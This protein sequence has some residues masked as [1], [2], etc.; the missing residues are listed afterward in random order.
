[1]K[2]TLNSQDFEVNEEKIELA[3]KYYYQLSNEVAY[4]LD[5]FIEGHNGRFLE[6]NDK[7]LLNRDVLEETKFLK[8]VR[9]FLNQEELKYSY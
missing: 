2:E 6:I 1:L 9:S 8:L 4:P 5:K 7:N 3:K